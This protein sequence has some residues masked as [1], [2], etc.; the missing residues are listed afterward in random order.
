MPKTSSRSGR[1]ARGGGYGGGGGIG[2]SGV[3]MMFGSVIQCP[4]DD[5]SFFCRLSKLV[6]TIFMLAFLLFIVYLI[7][8]F[9]SSKFSGRRK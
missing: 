5:T 9:L 3:H 4:V 8:R 2:G 6:Q 1:G 7:Y